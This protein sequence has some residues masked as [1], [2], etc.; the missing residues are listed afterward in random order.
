[1]PAGDFKAKVAKAVH[2]ALL[3]MGAKGFSDAHIEALIEVPPSRELGDY[4]FPCF[5]LAGALKKDPKKIAQE[6]AEG[7]NKS[8]EAMAELDTVSVVGGYI[9]FF[10]SR[11]GLAESTVEQVLAEGKKY[12]SGSGKNETVMVEFCESNTHKAFHIGHV[13]NISFGEALCRLLEFSGY[14]VLR[15]NYE[16]DVGPHVSKT[17][18][19]FLELH[20]GK[21]PKGRGV[22]KGEWLGKVYAEAS[23]KV[24]GNEELEQKMRD[25]VKELHDG[26]NKKLLALW[27]KTRKWS[28]DEF[29]RIYKDFG[30]KFNRLYFESEVEKPGISAARELLKK[31]IAEESEGAVIIDLKKEGLGVFVLL[32]QDGMPLY[33]AKDLGLIRL[34]TK[35]YK[36]GRSYHVVGAEQNF[37]FRQL[38]KTFELIGLPQAKKTRHISYELV[39]LEGG[40]MGSREGNVITYSELLNKVMG[41]CMGEVGKRH[42]DW[43]KAKSEKTAKAIAL[44]SIKFAMVS[45]ENQKVIIFNWE[46]ATELEGETGPYVQY[47]Y[48][49]A[50]S[51]LRKAKGEGKGT[52]AGKKSKFSARKTDY[53]LLTEEQEKNLVSA[54]AGF[55]QAVGQSAEHCAPHIMAQHMLKVAA[56]FNSFY[57]KVPVLNAERPE[58]RAAR[59]GLV[60]AGTIVLENGLTLLGI[61]ALEEM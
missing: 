16:G 54:L 25:L 21:E 5:K 46:R 44:S 12:G 49:R 50:R 33:S 36:F 34:K 51:I 2:S 40:K 23:K 29:D 45:R 14:K 22:N 61:E 13:R 24:K 11:A 4:A 39:M 35:E 47:A 41:K 27:K 32:K 52:A 58:L 53:G 19:G 28:L 38:I 20:N 17:L 56:A 60:K 26:K 57:Q 1:M 43:A 7:V 8:T 37:Y 15:V 6:L 55:G 48:A 9:N 18:W 42:K 3:S 31:G 59:L 10:V 30:V